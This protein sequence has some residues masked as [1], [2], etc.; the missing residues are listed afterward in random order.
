MNGKL[1]LL[2]LIIIIDT[3]VIL[4]SEWDRLNKK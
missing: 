1:F 4:K 2:G 3:Y